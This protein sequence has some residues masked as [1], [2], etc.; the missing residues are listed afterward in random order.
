MTSAAKPIPKAMI[1]C[2][3]KGIT[4]RQLILA[5][6]LDEPTAA[7]DP[8]AENEIYSRFNSFVQSK[9][10][11]YISHRLSS[12]VSIPSPCL[13]TQGWW[14]AARIQR[15]WLPTANMQRC[16]TRRQSIMCS[17]QQ[18][19]N[20]APGENEKMKEKA[21]KQTSVWMSAFFAKCGSVFIDIRPKM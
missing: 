13:I 12:C 10:A 6:V 15:F 8:I 4:T 11:I 19:N 14:K 21:K 5:V 20:A 7:L 18:H 1:D 16:G 3:E 2:I 17:L 9:T